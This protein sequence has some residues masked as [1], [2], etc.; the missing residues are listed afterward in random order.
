VRRTKLTDVAIGVVVFAAWDALSFSDRFSTLYET[1]VCGLASLISST[2]WLGEP[3]SMSAL[4]PGNFTNASFLAAAW[5]VQRLKTLP[6][7]IVIV[8]LIHSSRMQ[9]DLETKCRKCSH[10][11]RGIT[12]PRCPECGEKI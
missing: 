8:L 10:V 6:A 3:L 4:P 5:L 12:R 11:L 2:T 1:S 7:I 9:T